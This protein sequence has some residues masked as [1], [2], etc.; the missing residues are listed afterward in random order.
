MADNPVVRCGRKTCLWCRK[1][2]SNGEPLTDHQVEWAPAWAG[3]DSSGQFRRNHGQIAGR[4]QPAA[5]HADCWEMNR[6]CDARSRLI[7]LDESVI[8][9]GRELLGW[10]E[11]QIEAKVGVEVAELSAVVESVPVELRLRWL[12]SI[13]RPDQRML[14]EIDALETA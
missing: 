2:L 14:D 11:E 1:S 13:K 4:Q 8:E 7:Y 10:S 12:R 3:V 6:F 5:F 9:P